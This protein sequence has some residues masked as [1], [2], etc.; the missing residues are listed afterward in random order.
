MTSRWHTRWTED[1]VQL[2]KECAA[3]GFTTGQ[4]AERLGNGF[5]RNMVIGAAKRRGIRWARE[6]GESRTPKKVSS[7]PKERR[8]ITKK[9]ASKTLKLGGGGLDLTS[10]IDLPLPPDVPFDSPGVNLPE[11]GQCKWANGDS[12][13]WDFCTNRITKGVYCSE[14]YPRCYVDPRPR[15]PRPYGRGR[16]RVV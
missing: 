15:E 2:L 14:H 5:T 7:R 6:S 1:I 12:P 9:S 3:R 8:R 11:K 13:N 10:P 4:T 16:R